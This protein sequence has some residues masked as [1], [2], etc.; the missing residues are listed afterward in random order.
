MPATRARH[1][2]VIGITV[3]RHVPNSPDYVRLRQ[4]YTRAIVAAGGVPILLPPVEDDAAVEA[5]VDLVD[6]LLFPGGL[7]VEP[8]RYTDAPRHPNVVA[9]DALDALELRVAALAVGR[10]IPTLGI[11]RGQ[12]L[13]NVAL[14]GTLVQD[15]PDDLGVQ[16]SQ[17]GPVRDNL[18][19]GVELEADSRLANVLGTADVRVNSHH[20]QAVK[21]L[22]RGLRAV[23]WSPNDGVIEAIESVEHPWLLCVQF[24]PEDLVPRHAPSRRLFEAFVGACAERLGAEPVSASFSRIG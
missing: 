5:M 9:D 13:L 4:T 24:H 18:V 6:G 21:E 1:R 10:E 17:S 12:Q 19:H 15:I 14:G 11:C 2:P 23:G 20:H 8:E 22:G 3:G 7:D 16:H